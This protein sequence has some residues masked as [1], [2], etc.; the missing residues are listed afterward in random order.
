MLFWLLIQVLLNLGYTLFEQLAT[1]IVYPPI[2]ASTD[3]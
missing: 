3:L 1:A 2:L